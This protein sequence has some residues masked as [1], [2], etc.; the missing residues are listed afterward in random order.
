MSPVLQRHLRS[1]S[2]NLDGVDAALR[3]ASCLQERT[4]VAQLHTLAWEVVSLE[5]L[6]PVVLSMLVGGGNEKS[7]QWVTADIFWPSTAG[8]QGFLLQ[9]LHGVH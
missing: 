9:A 4:V 3:Q 7:S 5:Q 1:I 8:D 2:I 6:H